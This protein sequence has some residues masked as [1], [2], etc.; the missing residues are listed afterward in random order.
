MKDIFWQWKIPTVRRS[1]EHFIIHCEKKRRVDY[2]TVLRKPGPFSLSGRVLSETSTHLKR[3]NDHDGLAGIYARMC[4]ATLQKSCLAGPGARHP[5]RPRSGWS[6]YQD[7]V[8][9]LCSAV[10]SLRRP[11]T[12]MSSDAQGWMLGQ[13]EYVSSDL[14]SMRFSCRRIRPK[15]MHQFLRRNNLQLVISA[16]PRRFVRPP[17]PELRHV[18]E[19]S[20]LHML[21]RHL[22]H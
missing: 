21:I 14:A 4:A 1:R 10:P 5:A 12:R 20:A 9:T 2:T 3:D 6:L 17:A 15:D 13:G 18:A 7:S 8:A 11:H 16:L 19:T 22:D